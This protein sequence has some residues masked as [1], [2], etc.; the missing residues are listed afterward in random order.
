MAID[1]VAALRVQDD[2]AKN[3]A[4]EIRKALDRPDLTPD[5]AKRICDLVD[6]GLERFERFIASAA[7]QNLSPSYYA[8]LHILT[9]KW[10]AL[11]LE[12]S[13]RFESLAGSGAQ[14]EVVDDPAISAVEQ[15]GGGEHAS[16]DES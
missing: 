7:E 1:W 6:L 5:Q 15:S 2:L 9:D 4:K 8:A 3:V 16:P 11:A 10:H 14:R 12:A 13:S